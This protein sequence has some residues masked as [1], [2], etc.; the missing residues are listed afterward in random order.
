MFCDQ[1]GWVT[2]TE[3]I[4]MGIV[5][6]GPETRELVF[7]ISQLGFKSWLCHLYHGCLG[8]SC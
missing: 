7:G 6:A 2:E 1:C 5:G 3:L 8:A 4:S